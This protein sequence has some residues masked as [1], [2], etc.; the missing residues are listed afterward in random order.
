M[1]SASDDFNRANGSIGGNYTQDNGT[2]TVASNT[3]RQTNTGS[4][5]FK[6]RYTATEP[7]TAN[8]EV[9]ADCQ[10][11]NSAVGAGVGA[12]LANT[13]AVSGYALLG[14][15]GDTFYL[16]RLT[17]GADTYLDSG[18]T[19]NA[20]TVYNLR[21][22]CNGSTIEGYVDDVLT[23]SATDSTYASNTDVG[24]MSFGAINASDSNFDNLAW[25][26]L[27]VSAAPRSVFGGILRNDLPPRPAPTP[28]TV[29]IVAPRE[30][31]I[32]QTRA[33]W[34]LVLTSPPAPSPQHTAPSAFILPPR[35]ATAAA[36]RVP[37]ML[38]SAGDIVTLTDAQ[39]IALASQRAGQ[40]IRHSPSPY[41]TASAVHVLASLTEDN[42]TAVVTPAI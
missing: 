13:S 20:S 26:D 7:A 10:S 29:W 1:A 28:A 35:Q 27:A 3:A 16:V 11:D 36:E 21:L 4:S 15:G 34:P 14:F 18:G 2:W 9:E 42:L 8:H 31:T 37:P 40:F 19:C 6:C 33:S 39:L 24:L 17:A 5:Y 23:L 32:P 41:T 25:S 12:R 22:R 38:M 30:G